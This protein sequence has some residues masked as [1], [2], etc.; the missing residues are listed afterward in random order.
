[1]VHPGGWKVQLS[2]HDTGTAVAAFDPV[3]GVGLSTQPLYSDATNLPQMLIVGSY[4][5]VGRLGTFTPKR[6]AELEKAAQADLG[7]GYTV[8]VKYFSQAP[9]DGIELQVMRSEPASGH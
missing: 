4:Y 7:S 6:R 8:T 5:P 1:V 9:V 2:R 3:T